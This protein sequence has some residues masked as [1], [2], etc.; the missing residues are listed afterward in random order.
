ML[1]VLAEKHDI[2]LGTLK[3][4]K[5]REGWSRDPTKKDATKSEKVATIK[6]KDATKKKHGGQPG[7]RGNPKPA[8][9]FP[10]RNKA[11]EKHGLF[12]KFLP[13]ETKEIMDA[14]TDLSAA[15]LIWQQ[16]QIQF[17]A[18]IR[19]QK[20]MWVKHKEE[21]IKEIKKTETYSDDDS[22]SGK[23]EWE[24]Q[25]AWDRQ[26]TF[27]NAQ[28]RA[29]AEL[30]SLIKQFDELAHVHDERRLKMEQMRLTI[31]K[32]KMEIDKLGKNTEERPIQIM[33]KRK[34][35]RA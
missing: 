4:R 31:D 6:Q 10:K 7:N 33:I 2:K 24:F 19:S 8:I 21:M 16:I 20:I 1:T 35:E 26:A 5:S 22:T 32:T 28:S 29:M 11:A 27:L 18:I 12:S 15:D 9:K 23:Q 13:D 30:R 17:A 34:G 3:S 14:M 25:F